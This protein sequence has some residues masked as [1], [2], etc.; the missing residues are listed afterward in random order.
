MEADGF[1]PATFS[2]RVPIFP[3]PNV[4]LF[5]HGLLPLH[6]FEPRYREMARAALEGER[7]IAMALLKP[8]WE[9]DY[10]GRP[11]VHDVVGIGRVLQDARLPDGRFNL[12]LGGIARA[13]ILEEVGSRP[14]REARVV[15][16]SSR[17]SEGPV[18][19]RR[20]RLLLAFYL[21]RLREAIPPGRELPAPPDDVPLGDLC[22]LLLSVLE[23]DVGLRQEFLAELDVA[24]RAERLLRLIEGAGKRPAGPWPPAPSM[25]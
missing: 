7:L 18:A 11:A 14:Y 2:G 15:L 20:K 5:P 22:D 4:V 23:F 6:L 17:P 21:E 16:L 12:L 8:G 13:R 19:E 3:L 24:V 10:Q 1:D 9:A 25:N